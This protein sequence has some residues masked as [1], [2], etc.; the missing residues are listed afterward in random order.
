M[1]EAISSHSGAT[2]YHLLTGEVPF[3]GATHDE[4]VREKWQDSFRPV[5]E[6]NPSVPVTV[7]ELIES[8]L[9]CDPRERIQHA[10]QLANA[11]TTTKLAVQLPSFPQGQ[12]PRSDNES[13]ARND[14]PT[15]TDLPC[16][17]LSFVG[18]ERLKRCEGHDWQAAGATGLFG[19]R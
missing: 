9:A 7:A 4:V 17:I 12:I 19:R 8:T 15:R 18:H 16:V 11:L 10:G 13:V 6:L 2:L 14:T 5:R 1:A 3:V